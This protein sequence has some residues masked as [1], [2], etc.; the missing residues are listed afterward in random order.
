LRE[1]YAVTQE[2]VRDFLRELSRVPIK[3]RQAVLREFRAL[4]WVGKQRWLS[5]H[6]VSSPP[7]C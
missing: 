7:T 2:L 1:R 3:K 5:Q 4:S 6:S